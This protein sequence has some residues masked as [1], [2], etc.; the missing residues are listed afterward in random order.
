MV[1]FPENIEKAPFLARTSVLSLDKRGA[2]AFLQRV[3]SFG[4]FVLIPVRCRTFL[5]ASY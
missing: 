1:L 5:L 2:A 4:H 3:G